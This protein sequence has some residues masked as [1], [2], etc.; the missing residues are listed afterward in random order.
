[1]AKKSLFK[2]LYLNICGLIMV[3]G[4]LLAGLLTESTFFSIGPLSLTFVSFLLLAYI[5]KWQLAPLTQSLAAIENG[6]CAFNDSDFSLTI[7]NQHF[8]E[9]EQLVVI[10]NE[11]ANTLRNER[12][13]IFQRELLLDTVIQSTPVALVLTNKNGNIVYSN[14]AAKQLLKQNKKMEGAN[15]SQLQNNLSF[16]LQRATKAR[17][18]GLITDTEDEQSV[19]YNVDCRQFMLNGREHLLYLY[20]NMTSEISQKESEMWKQVIRLISHELNNS[21]APISSLTRSAQKIV[22]QPEHIHL[23]D[24]VLET[25]GNRAHHLHD[26]ISQYAKFARSPKPQ[27]KTVNLRQFFNQIKTLT[28]VNCQLDI[29]RENANFDPAQLEQVVINLIKNAKES[30]SELAEVSFTLKQQANMLNFIVADR[31]TGLTEVQ[32]Q[33][34]LLPFFTTKQTGTGIGLALCNEIVSNHDSQLRLNNREGGGLSVSFSLNLMNQN[35]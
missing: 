25:I 21:L 8:V 1:M 7:H 19:I 30:G 13:D 29:V 23:L 35:S 17:K 18:T 32:Q 31:G 11:L 14:I 28:D 22:K 16:A 6:I 4:F 15:F 33:Q 3:Y 27:S 12:M 5:F 2:R 26:F 20:K 24:E 34:A 10:Y 9:V